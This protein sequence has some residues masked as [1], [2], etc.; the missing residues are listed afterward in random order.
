MTVTRIKRLHCVLPS[1]S[2][3]S[4]VNFLSLPVSLSRYY[5]K[6]F[7]LS[8]L[9]LQPRRSNQR[10]EYSSVSLCILGICI[11]CFQWSLVWSGISRRARSTATTITVN[12]RNT[13]PTI[14]KERNVPLTEGKNRDFARNSPTELSFFGFFDQR[15]RVTTK[16]SGAR[17][18]FHF[19]DF[20]VRT[21]SQNPILLTKKRKEK[22]KRKRA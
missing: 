21:F 7:F 18:Y 3:S 9:N 8:T 10:M 11:N 14:Q 22:K 4:F 16:Q 13:K 12:I 17:I 2:R 19:S 1:F 15:A 5:C 6:C 20:F